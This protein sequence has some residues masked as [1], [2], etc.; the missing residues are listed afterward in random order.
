MESKLVN[1]PLLENFFQL[2]ELEIIYQKS[3]YYWFVII[4][5]PGDTHSVLSG[6]SRA[7]K[8]YVKE[9]KDRKITLRVRL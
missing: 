6:V 9:A 8:F 4:E 3:K 2:I 1:S 5:V 7:S